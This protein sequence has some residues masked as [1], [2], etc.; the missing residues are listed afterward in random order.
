MQDIVYSL[1]TE[2]VQLVAVENIGREL[3]AG[4][5][6]RLKDPI[7]EK[8]NWYD[9]IFSAISEECHKKEYHENKC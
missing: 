4:E 1:N 6:D 7:A 2:D 9:A 3:T 8:I 5:I